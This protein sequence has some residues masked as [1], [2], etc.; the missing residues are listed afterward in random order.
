[1]PRRLGTAALV[2]AVCAGVIAGCG[3]R[4]PSIAGDVA[5]ELNQVKCALERAEAEHANYE[6]AA[7]FRRS[8]RRFTGNERDDLSVEFN[9]V[10]IFGARIGD[11][12]RMERIIARLEA[13]EPSDDELA[14][15]NAASSDVAAAKTLMA[16]DRDNPPG[17]PNAPRPPAAIPGA[18]KAVVE[19]SEEDVKESIGTC[20]P[21]PDQRVRIRSYQG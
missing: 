15:I 5:A 4:L 9:R 3:G 19:A 1:M 8:G 13:D 21:P 2:L 10:R 18:L 17:A 12:N 11:L 7:S 16:H 14:L 6:A 20:T